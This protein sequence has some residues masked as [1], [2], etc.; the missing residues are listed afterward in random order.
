MKTLVILMFVVA[1]LCGCVQTSPPTGANVPDVS[2][3][4]SQI[5]EL[6]FDLGVLEKDHVFDCLIGE[7]EA[8]VVKEII[9]SCGCVGP[10]FDVGEKIDLFEPIKLYIS[11]ADK[12]AG[13]GTQDVLIR[14]ED[15]FAVRVTVNYVYL[16]LPSSMPEN[17]IFK[18]E[19]TDKLIV[20]VFPEESNVVVKDI[21][22][23]H[24]L[25]FFQTNELKKNTL[26]INIKITLERNKL[27]DEKSGVIRVVSSSKRKANFTIP[28]LV[29]LH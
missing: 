18:K 7:S 29:L 15:D 9:R 20:L 28:Y 11:L 3:S 19:E 23:P 26:S 21:T 24:F 1:M 4:M 13:P 27:S 6:E 22:L 12:L 16:P 8:K 2:S 5:K 25:T 14:F 10:N 17:L